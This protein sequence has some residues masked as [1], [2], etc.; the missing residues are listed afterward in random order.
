MNLCYLLSCYLKITF[1]FYGRDK[2]KSGRVLS[3]KEVERIKDVNAKMHTPCA[4]SKEKEAFVPEGDKRHTCPADYKE[5]LEIRR[6]WLAVMDS[7]V[8]G[9]I[10]PRLPQNT[11]SEIDV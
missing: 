4:V 9:M 7:M 5:H 3:V 10:N 11:G 6:Q 2:V 8:R 1:I